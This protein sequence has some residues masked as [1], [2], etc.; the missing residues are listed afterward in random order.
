[1]KKRLARI[2]NHIETTDTEMADASDSPLWV[3]RTADRRARQ[4]WYGA[5]HAPQR[6]RIASLISASN[7]LRTSPSSTARS[8]SSVALPS[9]LRSAYAHPRRKMSIALVGVEVYCRAEVFDR[10]VELTH[11]K[12]RDSPANMRPSIFPV[13]VY[14]GITHIKLPGP[15]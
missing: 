14:T 9:I 13:E 8:M 12:I 1:M 7:L 2:W 5:R 4:R 15:K 10:S 6:W 11:V 3:E